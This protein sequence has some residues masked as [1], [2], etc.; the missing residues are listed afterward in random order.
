MVH[1]PVMAM[2]QRW[3]RKYLIS[4][5]LMAVIAGSCLDE[6]QILFT[7]LVFSF[8]V[9]IALASLAKREGISKRQFLAIVIPI[10][11]FAVSVGVANLW[12]P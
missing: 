11:L 3:Y 2:P 5:V 9:A 6:G 12:W 4:T 7:F 10:V 8:P 1:N